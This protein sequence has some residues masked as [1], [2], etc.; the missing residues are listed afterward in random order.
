M[1]GKYGPNGPC[2]NPK[3]LDRVF[4]AYEILKDPQSPYYARAHVSQS[5]RQRLQFNLLPK[6]QRILISIQGFFLAGIA[7]T[8]LVLV[9]VLSFLPAR[10]SLRAATR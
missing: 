3:L 10:R 2:K 1:K 8:A 5:D 6:S 7:L 4:Q 9:V